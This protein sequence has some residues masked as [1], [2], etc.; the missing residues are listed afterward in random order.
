M[1][2]F[3]RVPR[4]SL[5]RLDPIGKGGQGKVYALPDLQL[6]DAA[7]PFAFKEYYDK[8]ISITGLDRMATFR[9][10]LSEAERDM[11]DTLA[12]WPVRVVEDGRDVADGLVLPL[13]AEGFFFEIRRGG[14]MRRRVRDGEFLCAA[15]ERCELAGVDYVALGDRLRVCRD[16]ALGVGFLHKRQVCLGDISFANFTYSLAA[17]PC[18]YLIDCD[19]FRLKGQAAVVPQLHTPDWSPPEG[20]RAQ[21]QETDLYKLGLC[22]LRLLSPRA[23]SGQNRDPSWADA[24]LDGPGRSL[25]RRA[26]GSEAGARTTAKEWYAYLENL[27]VSRKPPVTPSVARRPGS[28]T[29]V[30]AERLASRRRSRLARLPP[31]ACPQFQ[32]RAGRRLSRGAQRR[33]EVAFVRLPN[34]ARTA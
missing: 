10:R 17:D 9:R 23:Q 31:L 14:E 25:L 2:S 34:A 16:L 18:V 8:T 1:S 27:L 33:P 5:G 19:A 22:I 30:R 26:L 11:L 32:R 29:A 15:Q 21:S 24:A 13:I 6:N 3:E 7:G 12:N 20:A 4:A 28:P